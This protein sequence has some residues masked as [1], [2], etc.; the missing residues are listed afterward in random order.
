MKDNK[1]QSRSIT[2]WKQNSSVLVFLE[3]TSFGFKQLKYWLLQI[4]F[5]PHTSFMVF[6]GLC[7][8][9]DKISIWEIGLT[10]LGHSLHH[11][12]VGN[13]QVFETYGS[14]VS[15]THQPRNY[16][17][18]DLHFFVSVFTH[19]VRTTIAT[20]RHSQVNGMKPIV[21]CLI[22]VKFSIYV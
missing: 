11:P 18:A 21:Q 10:L 4:P 2:N 5:T 16:Q 12:I 8:G 15:A 19:N 1:N 13:A 17:A 20:C 3:S 6:F 14:S 7:L 9:S 22:H